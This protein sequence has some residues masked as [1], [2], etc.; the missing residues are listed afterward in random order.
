MI[1]D[2]VSALVFRAC[3]LRGRVA[4]AKVLSAGAESDCVGLGPRRMHATPRGI[5]VPARQI[6]TRREGQGRQ[7]GSRQVRS[8]P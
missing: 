7:G 2:T 8:C 1:S 4:R 3:G 5:G 6:E